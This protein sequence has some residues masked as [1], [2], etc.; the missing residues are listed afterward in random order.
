MMPVSPA[1]LTQ[2][3][4][5]AVTAF[6]RLRRNEP[7]AL[8]ID[9]ALQK[10]IIW[11]R[12]HILFGP[13]A[14]SVCTAQGLPTN[15]DWHQTGPPRDRQP[16]WHLFWLCTSAVHQPRPLRNTKTLR[17][18]RP[19]H[20]VQCPSPLFADQQRQTPLP[21]P[22][23]LRP[24]PQRHHLTD[25]SWPSCAISSDEQIAVVPRCA[26]MSAKAVGEGPFMF[27]GRSQCTRCSA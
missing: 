16:K 6:Y 13:A 5:G 9:K 7:F 27:S 23:A 10:N 3:L 8:P 17:L 12:Y 1:S 26:L 2:R 21:A 14:Q 22:C 20:C 11:A 4:I 15:C 19:G 18:V 24:E 25:S